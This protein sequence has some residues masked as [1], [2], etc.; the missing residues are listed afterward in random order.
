MNRKELS[1]LFYLEQEL[2]RCEENLAELRASIKPLAQK[3]TGM[4][5]QNT[6]ETS[7]P[8]QKIVFQLMKAEQAVDGYKQAIMIRKAKI[9]EWIA[10]LDDAL[11][12]QI[13]DY[14]CVRL[15]SWEDVAKK[16]GGGNTED[17]VKKYFYRNIEK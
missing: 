11:L 12:A 3:I 6:G 17:S 14:R 10:F 16:V 13:V 15:M 4:P 5:F 9:Y 7:D 1:Q 2:K 8:V